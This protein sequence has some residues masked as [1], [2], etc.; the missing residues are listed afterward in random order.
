MIVAIHQ[1]NYLPYLGFF[2]KIFNS[3]VF[4]ILDDAQFSKGDFHNRNRIKNQN[5]AKW[6][7]IPVKAEFKSIRDIKIN[8][9][10]KFSNNSWN[11]YH[12]LQIKENYKNSKCFN[13][14]YPKIEK[15]LKQD[16]QFLLDIN[17]KMIYLLTE[18]FNINVKIVLS[19]ILKISTNSTQRLIDITK[20]LAGDTYL[21]GTG[22]KSYID[23]NLFKENGINLIFQEFEHPY[24]KQQ[25]ENFVP[26]LS[27]IDYCFNEGGNLFA[28]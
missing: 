28:K 13:S 14:L 1:P 16:Y 22:A 11:D 25:Y 10:F 12:L 3:D 23:I 15:I 24:Y 9:E 5:G 27:A 18:Y 6:L 4:V 7:T 17:L 20:Y 19:S 26:N 2:D 21:S 8:Q